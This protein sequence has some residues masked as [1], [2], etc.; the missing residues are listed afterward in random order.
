MRQ[1]SRTVYASGSDTV[2]DTASATAAVGSVRIS[3]TSTDRVA[4]VSAE[5]ETAEASAIRITVT[6]MRGVWRDMGLLR[7]WNLPLVSNGC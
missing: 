7:L 2:A 4:A 5:M 3:A 1:N 6:A